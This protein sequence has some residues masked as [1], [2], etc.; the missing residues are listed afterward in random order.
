MTSG[1]LGVTAISLLGALADFLNEIVI[2]NQVPQCICP[3][4]YR[5]RLIAL[6]KSDD[7]IRPIT[8]GLTIRRLAEKVSMSNLR[9]V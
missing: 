5:A 6:A 7:G 8:M 4:F 2:S 9:D 3:I 1:Q